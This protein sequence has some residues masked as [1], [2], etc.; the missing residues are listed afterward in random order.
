MLERKITTDDDREKGVDTWSID[1][2]KT[3]QK[4]VLAKQKLLAP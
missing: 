1:G 3:K 2:K 4:Q